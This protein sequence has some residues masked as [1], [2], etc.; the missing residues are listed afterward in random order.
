[1][2][3]K[4]LHFVANKGDLLLKWKYFV[5]IYLKKYTFII[6]QQ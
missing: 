4:H 2:K 3:I 6:F 5:I 1:M